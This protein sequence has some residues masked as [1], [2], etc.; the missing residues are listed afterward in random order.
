MPPRRQRPCAP[1]PIDALGSRGQSLGV[2]Q[3]RSVAS[4][5]AG[6]DADPSRIAW[7]EIYRTV[8]DAQRAGETA[9]LAE[10]LDALRP[11]TPGD[12]RWSAPQHLAQF[13]C[14]ALA[15]VPTYEAAYALVSRAATC[16]QRPL[17][18]AALAQTHPVATWEDL[19]RLAWRQ[20]APRALLTL[21]M[22]EA[23]YLGADLTAAVEPIAL[24]RR[25]F[26]AFEGEARVPLA[27]V[28]WE[29]ELPRS[30]PHITAQS[31]G[32][33]RVGS[34]VPR[35]PPDP[36]PAVPMA[37]VEVPEPAWVQRVA[38]AFVPRG[39]LSNA[40]VE[41]RRFL[42]ARPLD[43]DALGAPVL[44][45]LS[46]ARVAR[47]DDVGDEDA[48]LLP[49]APEV[50]VRVQPSSPQT[51]A[52]SLL[53]AA[54][55][56]RCYGQYAGVGPG[57]RRAWNA[58]AALC[59]LSA[60]APWAQVAAE[61]GERRVVAFDADSAWFDHIGDDLGF[62]VLDAAGTTLTLFAAT[63]SD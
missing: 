31:Y 44:R 46:P 16:T 24:L 14:R 1:R 51:L 63:D 9:W 42:L 59:D 2:T 57:R 13:A 17:V 53:H 26:E 21:W 36:R 4:V 11:A 6:L 58:L 10:L 18:A 48:T 23:V 30:P 34:G 39:T 7:P 3:T 47:G 43:P 35:P 49:L 61:L 40:K 52:A 38:E 8:V 50:E 45:A 56:A 25:D 41:A 37:C 20:R 28:S 22:H 27:L 54:I 55:G 5:V 15:T 12:T 33:W 19:A 29:R 60:D 32:S 62:L